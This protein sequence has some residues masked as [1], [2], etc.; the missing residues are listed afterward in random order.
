MQMVDNELPSVIEQVKIAT[1]EC[2]V[3]VSADAAK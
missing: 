3:I 1:Q 2:Y